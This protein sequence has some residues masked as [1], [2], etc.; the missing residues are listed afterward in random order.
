MHY[1]HRTKFL[2]AIDGDTVDVEIDMGFRIFSKQRLRLARI[3]ACEMRSQVPGEKEK[4]IRARDYIELFFKSHPEAPLTI[5]TEKTD[6]Y[7]RYV[8]E[9]E[10]GEINLSDELLNAGIVMHYPKERPE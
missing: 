2:K 1:G 4:A 3:D 10:L 7:G 8:A 9:V 5:H 6:K